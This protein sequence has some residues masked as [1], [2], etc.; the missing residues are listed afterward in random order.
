MST[1]NKPRLITSFEKLDLEMQEQIK[2]D[3]PEGFSE[4]LIKFTNRDGELISALRFE[5]EDKIYLVKMSRIV[6]EQLIEDDDDYDEDGNLT[7]EAREE[8]EDKYEDEELE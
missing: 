5:T 6:A 4:N 8:Y 1:Q 3:N 7:D 2:L